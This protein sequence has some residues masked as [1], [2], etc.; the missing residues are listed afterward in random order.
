LNKVG[1]DPLV[2]SAYDTAL[3][4]APWRTNPNFV[5]A[6]LVAADL[7]PNLL[8]NYHLLDNTSPAYN[9]GAASKNGVAA[10][11]TDIDGQARPALGGFDSGADEIP[12]PTADLSIT[13]SD[14][15]TTVLP[16][17]A[18]SYAIAVSNAGPIG[19]A[20][21]PVNDTVPAA[22]TNVSWTCAPAALC[23]AASGTGNISTTV[24]L[25]VGAS[26][27]F[28]LNGTVAANATPGALTNTATVA[29]PAGG[30]TDPNPANNSATDTDAIVLALPSLTV[31]DN[32]N[33]TNAANLG[34]NWSQPNNNIRLN[35]NQAQENTGTTG[36]AYWNG[37]TGGGPTYGARQ[38]AGLT[39]ANTTLTG[40]SLILKA[41]GGTATAPTSYL[42]VRLTATTVI[43]ESTTNGGSGF[44]TRGTL[45]A[46]FANTNTL[47]AVANADGSVDVWQNA[48]YLGRSAA[49]AAFSGTGR[50][51]MSLPNGARVDNFSGGTLP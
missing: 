47:T 35:N 42:R 34:A 22:L 40:D 31:L 27:T 25:G 48:T 41:S 5:G 50:V 11:T 26:A 14:G 16:G 38:G 23:G 45:T 24:T 1:T 43:V 18:V 17:G 19:V 15:L 46:T 36:F 12:A 3:S 37:G 30:T 8:G 51:G 33:R 32:F 44:T 29:V 39:I 9:A 21:A 28:T 7:P 13:V 6:I 49:V 20:G 10:P 2:A 4:F